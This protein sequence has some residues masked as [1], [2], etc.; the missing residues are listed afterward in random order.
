MPETRVNALAMLLGAA[1]TGIPMTALAQRS[2]RALAP[3]EVVTPATFDQAVARG[4]RTLAGAP[5]PAYWQN[6]AD[7]EITARITPA[8]SI[9]RGEERVTYHNHSP[10]T[11]NAVVFHLYQNL[12]GPY[13]AREQPVSGFTR[14]MVVDALWAGDGYVEVP[15]NQIGI[16]SDSTGARILGTLMLVPLRTP[17]PPG[18]S[19]SFRV[20]WHFT[21]PPATAPRMGMQD[22]TTGQVAQWYPQI[23]VYDDLHGWDLQQYT[24]TGE[25]Y[26]DYGNF[27]YSITVPAGYIVGG[28]GTLAN[29]DVL[30]SSARAA[31]ER[32]AT[33]DGV[34]HVISAGDITAN[35]AGPQSWSTWT[36][37]ADN[38]RDIAFSFSD[39]YLWDA[40]S[41]VV[42]STSGRRALVNVFYRQG[43][44]LFDRVWQMAQAA[45]ETH[46]SRLTPYPWT[47]LTVTEGGSG[48]MEYPMTVFVQAY[49]DLYRADE[50]T[51]HEIGHEWFPML[52]GSNETRYGW[53]DEGLNTFDT[54]FATDAFLPDSLRGR[55]L[56]ESR[57]EYIDFVNHVDEDLT[58]MSPANAFGVA[59]SGYVVEAYSKPSAMLWALRSILGA[60]VFDRACRRYIDEWSYRHPTPW[61]FFNTFS[62]ET[63]EDLA[64]FFQPWFFGRGVL[65]QAVTGVVEENGR[66]I[67]T[68]EN[69]GQ[70]YAPIDVTATLADGTTV[71]WREP[72]SIWYD[73]SGEVETSHAVSGRVVRVALDA[74]RN[75]PD[76]EPGN[77]VWPASH[78]AARPEEPGRGGARPHSP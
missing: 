44:P 68:V 15:D 4:T 31:L 12:M 17:L 56:A 63:G 11:L 13:A 75:F 60:P 20:H 58:I 19:A 73:G 38:V 64:A 66:I 24:G 23:A 25:F 3:I 74:A 22:A 36:F 55:G 65:D 71:K 77:N 53:Q 8:D 50:V 47:Q 54:F 59:G 7:Y 69:R 30:A 39:H 26:L 27:R 48:G 42:D 16:A 67:V 21:L 5:G 45:L 51:A 52:V 6:S 34:E 29:P 70:L 37:S 72:M 10:D 78:A 9:L 43:A 49:S 46:S 62:S 18:G 61:D 1:L 33:S 14:G 35:E 76:V 32:A 40:T 2:P 41:A 57:Q 28:T